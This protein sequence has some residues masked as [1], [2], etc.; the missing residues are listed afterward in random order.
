MT[1]THR[2]LSNIH[3]EHGYVVAIVLLVVL[4]AGVNWIMEPEQA[5]RWLRGMLTLPLLWFGLT[6]AYV[7]T[8][9]SRPA[10]DTDDEMAKERYFLSA[11]TLGA[12][13]VGIRQIAVFGLEIW[14]RLGDHGADLEFERRILG[15]A[16]SA[17]F[18]VIGNALPK[19]L[20]PLSVLP[21][22]LA[23]RQTSA[24][25]FI[26]AT[27]VILGLALAI[28]FMVLPL[29]VAK[30]IGRWE[31]IGGL[32]TVFGAIVWMNAGP[33]RREQ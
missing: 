18:I 16:T 4:L 32:L 29:D 31:A 15:L 20:T 7:W 19:I 9:R 23:E 12:V 11:L 17:V 21:L 6:F 14:V 8:R 33:A 30:T 3:H 28:A 24:R 10:S 25:R 26:G 2:T 13:A 1:P 27:F 5:L 22:P